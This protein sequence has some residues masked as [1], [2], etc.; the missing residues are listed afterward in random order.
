MPE[1]RGII[2]TTNKWGK[3]TATSWIPCLK[4]DENKSPCKFDI[5]N[6]VFG[7]V[8]LYIPKLLQKLN[9][10][11]IHTSQSDKEP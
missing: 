8:Y 2:I 7:C 9:A 6:Y 3:A 10:K 5:L 1:R 11:S 4:K